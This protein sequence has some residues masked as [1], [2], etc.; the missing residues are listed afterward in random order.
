MPKKI[1]GKVQ[2]FDID[3]DS[4]LYTC[5]ANDI[6]NNDSPARIGDVIVCEE[7]GQEMCLQECKDGTIKWQARS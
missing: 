2:D 1:I 5:C 7:C 4:G 6:M 3:F